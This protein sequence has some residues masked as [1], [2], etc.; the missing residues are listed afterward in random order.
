[1]TWP[2]SADL[3]RAAEA[4]AGRLPAELRVLAE[5][6]FNY[7]WSWLPGG[8]EVFRDVDPYRWEARREN[9]VRLLLEVPGESLARAARSEDLLARAQAVHRAI[10]E[11]I[12]R[13]FSR[14]SP[15]RPV[16]F[17]CAEFGVH[18]SLPTYGGGLGILAGDILKEASD[19]AL[20]MVGVGILYR[21][22]NLHQAID[23]TGW[24]TQTWT[25][26]DPDR[27]PIALVMGEDGAP[28]TI[29]VPLRGRDVVAQVWRADVGRVPLYFLDTQRPENSQVDRWIT[30]RLY[31]ADRTIRLAQYALLGIGAIRALRAMGIDPSV[32]HVN[33]GHGA[34]AALELA[35]EEVAAG[36]SFQDALEAARARIVFTTHTPVPAGNETYSPTEIAEA[37]G[38]LAGPL[39]AD[40]R[41]V[42]GLGRSRP[43]DEDE[44]LGLT[45]LAI[46]TARKVNAVSRLHGQVARLM[47]QH[48]FPGRGMN[49][50]PIDHVTNG[51]HLPTW[52]APRMRALLDRHLGSGW[53]DRAADASTWQAVDGIPDDELWAVRG[54]LRAALVDYVD[55]RSVRDRLARGEPIDYAETGASAFDPEVLTV[56]FARRVAAYKRLDLLIHDLDRARQLLQ[57]PRPIQVVLAGKAHPA[58]MDAKLI[59]QR[60]FL[61]KL[62]PNGGDRAVLLEDYGMGMAARLV[63]GCDVWLNLPR[64]PLEAS[65]TSG[66]K[67]ALNG[68]LNLSVLDG[69]WAEAYD[70]TNGWAIEGDASLEPEA[71]DDIDGKMLYELIEREVVPLFYDRDEAGIPRGW[72]QRVKA[73]LRTIGPRFCATRMLQEYADRIYGI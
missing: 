47:W 71:Q 70:G 39:H 58:D 61:V 1:V 53:Q 57:G 38:D 52:M 13:P 64:P 19:R 30:A 29:N 48:L 27:L 62:S 24:Q 10:R 41:T 36:R 22:G 23:I 66:M 59:L 65:G 67:S 31:I 72:V 42:L 43:E 17:L 68:G 4:L 20:P 6:A 12:E 7:R 35:R 45:V 69:W 54:A 16:A 21:Q 28:L 9:P 14:G 3:A 40:P 25:E 73:S 34:M 5:I 18:R 46:R 51:V 44:P 50:I 33:E 15:D 37:L 32:I 60:V 26:S 49:E 63:S 56:G 55:D 11:D 2:G 8:P